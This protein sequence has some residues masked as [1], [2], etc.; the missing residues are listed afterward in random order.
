[1]EMLK[2]VIHLVLQFATG[3][4]P[5]IYFL[6]LVALPFLLVI[7]E[8]FIRKIIGQPLKRNKDVLQTLGYAAIGVIVYL[9]L[10]RT[11]VSLLISFTSI[12][13]NNQ[14][15]IFIGLL[16][17]VL[18]AL[19]S[20]LTA[21]YILMNGKLY[22]FLYLSGSTLIFICLMNWVSMGINGNL[23]I[24]FYIYLGFGLFY[25]VCSIANTKVILMEKKQA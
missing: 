21:F 5:L 20:P 2:D 18:I 15:V 19:L 8:L 14:E 24:P 17:L 25:F 7:S 1:M 3:E 4:L 11:I 12:D 23:H 13:W 16:T 9:F 22:K 10:F 6:I